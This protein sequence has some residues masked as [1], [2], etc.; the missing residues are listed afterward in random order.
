MLQFNFTV[1]SYLQKPKR[2]HLFDYTN[3]KNI[4]KQ[5]DKEL[6]LGQMGQIHKRI[7]QRV[8]KRRPLTFV[9]YSYHHLP[10]S[11]LV[12]RATDHLLTNRNM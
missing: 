1:L 5:D 11:Y 3:T 9:R 4:L 10:R 8:R 7:R 12:I 2:I 6:F